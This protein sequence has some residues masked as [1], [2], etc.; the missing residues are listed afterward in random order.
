MRGTASGDVLKLGLYATVSVWLGAWVSPLFY[1]AG[2][3]LA[4]VSSTKMTNGPLLWLAGRCNAADFPDFFEKSLLLVAAILFW[5]FIQSLR[6]GH[7]AEEGQR[8]QRNPRGLW[9]AAAGF[10]GITVTFCLMAGGL[11]VLGIFEWK[12]PGNLGLRFVLKMLAGAFALAIFQEILFRGIALG[13]FL[14]AMRPAA[15]LVLA[16]ALFAG[17]HFLHPPP[18]L[19]VPDPDAAGV[20]FQMLRKIVAQVSE[21]RIVFGTFLPLLAL[22][23]LLAFARWRTASLSLPIGLHAGWLFVHDFMGG[24]MAAPGR[25]DLPLWVISGT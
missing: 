16:A 24:M 2:K 6:G 25:S 23:G 21:P 7:L 9:Q 11:V 12:N 4:E 20:G 18:G 5:P 19:N 8:L 10:L 15:A 22:G 3:A 14:R 17:V 13:I 1:N